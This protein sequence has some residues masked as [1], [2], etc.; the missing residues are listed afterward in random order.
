MLDAPTRNLFQAI[1]D[2]DLE[3]FKQALTG[4]A[5]V[6]V[7][8][9][10]SMT[11]LMF[12]ANAYIVS[13]DQPTLEKT[14]KLLIQNS[15][16][17]I[18]A[19]SREHVYEQRQK[20]DQYGREV[21]SFLVQGEQKE[22]VAMRS[23]HYIYCENG[24]PVSGEDGQRFIH[25]NSYYD[26][27]MESVKTDNM[28]EDTALHIACQVGAKDIVKI[29]LTHSGIETDI[30][31]CECKSPKGCITRGSEEIIKLEFEKAQRGR[32]LLTA[33]SNGNINQAKTLLSQELNSNCWNRTRDGGIETPLSLIIRLCSERITEDKRKVL[34]KLLKHKEL[35]FSQIKPQAIEQNPQLKQIIEQS[36]TERLTGVISEKDLEGVK[37]LVEDNCFMNHA[38]VAAALRGVDDPIESIT[39]YLNEKFPASAAQPLANTHNVSPEINDELIAQE[40]QQLENI[41]GE[42]E[43][44]KIQ[45]TKKEGELNNVKRDLSNEI[46]NKNSNILQLKEDLR[47]AEQD[48]KGQQ[49]RIN[50]LNSE[51]TQLTKENIQLYTQNQSL[52]DKNKKFSGTNTWS[53]RQSNYASALFV[54]SGTFAVGVYLTISDPLIYAPLAVAALT[55]L[56]AGC[57][58]A[59]KANTVLSDVKSSQATGNPVNTIAY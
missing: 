26:S 33:L 9:E 25:I 20:R 3:G 32:Q 40:L 19:Q 52:N 24:Q 1:D 54:L 2:E 43:R 10:E 59:C 6:N 39:N 31:N 36:I 13:N 22:V 14:A 29:L 44:T 45:L 11:P 12:I 41:R 48:K 21:Y 35:D 51:I 50:D 28:K 23:G 47:Q 5:N 49:I 53:G 34:T 4:G 18:N 16:I 15:G 8:D 58:C 37:K 17:N 55:F 7:F 30:R 27:I 42:L 38:I 57:Y 56:A 46:S